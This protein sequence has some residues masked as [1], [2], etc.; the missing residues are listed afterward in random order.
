MLSH[1]NPPEVVLIPIEAVK[2]FL[3]FHR[4]AQSPIFCGGSV[5]SNQVQ[6]QTGSE[7]ADAVTNFIFFKLLNEKQIVTKLCYEPVKTKVNYDFLAMTL[8][9]AKLAD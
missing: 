9:L 5:K 4:T 2:V 6:Y 8:W 7:R 3:V 1:L